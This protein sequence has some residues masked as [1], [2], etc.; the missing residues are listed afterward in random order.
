MNTFL[1]SVVQGLGLACGIALA[2]VVLRAIF[3]VGVCG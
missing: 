1:S 3:H 2:S